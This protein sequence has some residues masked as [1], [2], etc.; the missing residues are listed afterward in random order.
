[1]LN[2]Q[3]LEALFADDESDHVERKPSLKQRREIQRSVCAFAN[4]LSASGQVGVIFIGVE[5]DR[6]C[7]KLPITDELL[8][9]LSDLSTDGGILPPPVIRVQKLT[10]RSC[11]VAVVEVKPADN[12]P[13]RCRGTIWVRIGPRLKTASA[14]EE[15]R[16]SERR[17]ATD[18][19][20]D[21]RPVTDANM[22]DLDCNNFA[23]EYLTSAIDH[24][25]LKENQR[26]IEQQLVSLRFMTPTGTLVNGALL[27][28]GRDPLRWL[29]GAYV[30]FLRI[31]GTEL[32]DPI[33][34]QKEL[35][36]TLHE[37]LS[38]LDDLLAIN[39]STRTD[40][41]GKPRETRQ[42][43]YPLV[44]LQQL[45]RNAI[46]HRT[47]EGTNTPVRIYWFSDRVEIYSPGGLY[48]Q[49]NPDNFGKGATDYRNPL[50]A[51]A[52]NVLG[53]V[54]RFGL[55]IPSAKQELKKNG[56]QPPEFDF[57]P[58]SVLVTLKRC[59]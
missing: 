58:E 5:D 18:R 49:V 51:E 19:P 26:G 35:S 10:F 48:G 16:L 28:F 29:P 27:T 20:F 36:G 46:M 45:T 1:M 34:H 50:V 23:Q 8:R 56:N 7:S 4:D 21:L 37:V 6:S 40:P 57:R 15:R 32:T 39:I 53:Y 52:M 30:Q 59:G 43:D 47:Y 31:D 22:A 44:A 14:E 13:V 12:P 3:A 24:D 9:N 2:E 38:R 54:Q 11:E 17:R 55:G 42:P 33:R 25:V 41:V